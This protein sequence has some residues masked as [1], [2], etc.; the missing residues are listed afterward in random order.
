[1]S[2]MLALA[3]LMFMVCESARM[4]PVLDSFA[5]GWKTGTHY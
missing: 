1:M 4:N 3:G 5:G 2:V